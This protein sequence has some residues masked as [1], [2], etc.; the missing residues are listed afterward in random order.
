MGGEL[1]DRGRVAHLCAFPADEPQPRD[2][3]TCQGIAGPLSR[4]RRVVY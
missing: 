3:R 2:D 1:E 4:R